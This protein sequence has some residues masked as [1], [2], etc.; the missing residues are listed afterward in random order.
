METNPTPPLMTKKEEDEVEKVF[1]KIDVDGDGKISETELG[2]V[3]CGLG[4]TT[5][6]DEMA[7]VMSDLDADGDGYIDLNE[8]KS[9][10]W[11]GGGDGE[12]QEA[13]DL[14][15]KD[16]DGKITAAELQSVLRG[17]GEESSVEDCRRMIGAFDV[18]GDGCIDFEE[19]RKMMIGDSQLN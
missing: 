9:F 7:V 3:L 1:H 6:A 19:F 16:R 12:L 13:F 15:D 4:S 11:L 10:R 2:A 5:T 18:D 17:L 14:Y 8:F